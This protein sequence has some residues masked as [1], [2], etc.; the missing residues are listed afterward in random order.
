V[1]E[2]IREAGSTNVLSSV[3]FFT[4]F[5]PSARLKNSGSATNR[6]SRFTESPPP[7]L[8]SPFRKAESFL[9]PSINAVVE[10]IKDAIARIYSSNTVKLSSFLE[11]AAL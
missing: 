6:I 4:L 8:Y 5:P 11:V 1:P 7:Y 9:E 2:R 10:G 3:S